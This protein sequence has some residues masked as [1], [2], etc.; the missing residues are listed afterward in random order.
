MG[1][2]RPEAL[3]QGK[4]KPRAKEHLDPAGLLALASQAESASYL[5]E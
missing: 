4:A 2:F 5:R 1:S 3:G